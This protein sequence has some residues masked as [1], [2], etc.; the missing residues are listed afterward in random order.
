MGSK[1]EFIVGCF[2]SEYPK[3][4]CENIYFITYNG[5]SIYR[6]RSICKSSLNSHS[7]FSPPHLLTAIGWYGNLILNIDLQ[8]TSSF[9]NIICENELSMQFLS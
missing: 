8:V 3:P 7:F 6:C 4:V 9:V 1:M 2:S 5:S